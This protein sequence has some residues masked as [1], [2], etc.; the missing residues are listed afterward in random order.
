MTTDALITIG[1]VLMVSMFVSG[2]L[3][4]KG[5]AYKTLS[6]AEKEPAK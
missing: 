2:Y 4:G 1:L 5:C 6:A 3:V